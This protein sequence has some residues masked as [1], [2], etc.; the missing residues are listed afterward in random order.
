LDFGQRIAIADPV[1]YLQSMGNDCHR[2]GSPLATPETFCPNCGS[3]QLLYDSSGDVANGSTGVAPPALRNVDWKQA[4]GAAVTFAVPVG[5]LCSS[6]VP[7]LA[8]GCCL[9]VLAGS[10]AGVWLYQRRSGTRA[11]P[12]PVG[13]RIGTILGLIASAIAAAFNAGATVFVRYVLHGGDAMEKAFQTSMEQGSMMASQLMSASPDQAKEAMRF[14]LSP[15][16]RA[17]ATLLT[18]A[19]FSIGITVFSTIG[20]ALGTRIFS[21]PNPSVSN[22]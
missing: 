22:S 11:L 13:M 5:L 7:V 14:W 2:C 1:G 6:V 4:I 18:A 15:D 12:R 3:P 21:G 17:A 16:G 19:M 8:S 20:G 10:I 9:W